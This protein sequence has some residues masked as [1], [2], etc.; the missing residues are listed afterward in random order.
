MLFW[1]YVLL[2]KVFAGLNSFFCYASSEWTLYEMY[3]RADAYWESIDLTEHN[4]RLEE[5]RILNERRSRR[6]QPAE[7]TGI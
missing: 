1:V 7:E 3:Q 4:S 2:L 5:Q 6:N